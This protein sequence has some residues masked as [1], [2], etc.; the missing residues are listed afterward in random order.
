MWNDI[1]LTKLNVKTIELIK[2]QRSQVELS[3]K[4]IDKIYYD[5]MGCRALISDDDCVTTVL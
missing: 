1:K 5:K 3:S 4:I 2:V